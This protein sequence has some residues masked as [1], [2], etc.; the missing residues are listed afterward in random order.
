MLWINANYALAQEHVGEVIHRLDKVGFENI[1]V[2]AEGKT[3]ILSYENTLYRDKSFALSK[4]LEQISNCGYDTLKIVT[5]V[6][7][8][9]VIVSQLKIGN[10][11]HD[12][13]EQ[14][15]TTKNANSFNLSY[16][17]DATWKLI[18][19]EL[20]INPHFNK[21][22]LV[23]Y[24]QFYLMNIRLDQ[25]YEVQINIAP[26]IEASL[27]RG[28]KFTGQ[29]II[30]V[31]S[32]YTFGSEG[33]KPRLG[34]VTMSQEFHLPHAIFGRFAVGKFNAGRYGADMTLKHYLLDEQ[35]YLKIN[36]GYTGEYLYYDGNWFRNQINTL[37]WSV[38]GGYFW[39]KYNLQL[40][41]SAGRYI[42]SDYG[43]RGD[44]TR[45]WG[46]TAVGLFAMVSSEGSFSGG[47]HFALPIGPKQRKKY[48]IFQLQTPNYFDWEYNTDATTTNGQY[49]ETRP[50]ENRVEHFFNRNLF[51][52]N[53][54]K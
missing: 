9:P 1:R 41:G 23:L 18:R 37:T 25:I 44:C 14:I 51:L 22:A 33:K 5:L 8:M 24:P 48:R 46:G 28:M 30:P 3:L 42:Q 32:D 50:D 6:N 38:G 21:I 31:F 36:S 39:R 40:E 20:P 35:G 49:Y 26:A 7:D 10:S 11:Q 29:V 2:K 17:T 52:K 4:V 45:Y 27:W 15:S 12:E 34:F 19:N 53:P 16:K 13:S 54:V 43:L 47:F